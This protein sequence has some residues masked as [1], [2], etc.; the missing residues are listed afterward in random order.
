MK[1]AFI[2]MLAAAVCL[3]P[4]FAARGADF[5]WA[6]AAVGGAWTDANMWQGGSGGYPDGAGASAAISMQSIDVCGIDDVTVGSLS[7]TLA[8]ANRKLLGT[9]LTFDN[10]GAPGVLNVSDSW[11]GSGDPTRLLVPIALAGDLSVTV[12]GDRAFAIWG[13]I[14]EI[15]QARR[16]TLH[17]SAGTGAPVLRAAGSAWTLTGG[18][19]LAGGADAAHYATFAD[20]EAVYD[21]AVHMGGYSRYVSD[22]AANVT[23]G[24]PVVLSP[25]CHA[26][27]GCVTLESEPPSFP[28]S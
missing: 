6:D 27:V 15:G 22:I 2:A 17:A 25:G 10:A 26:V 28:T 7:V 12:S 14:S 23:L 4:A 3:S 16:L 9:G 21:G 8:N 19:Y 11:S 1:L 20:N 24:S 13:G 18:V 5:T